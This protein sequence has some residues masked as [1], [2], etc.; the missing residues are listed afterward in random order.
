MNAKR[1]PATPQRTI[2]A[3]ARVPRIH[4]HIG[5]LMLEN[6]TRSDQLRFTRT[7]ELTL[8]EFA[9]TAHDL[10]WSRVQ[11]PARINVGSLRPGAT[12]EQAARQIARHI[13]L[14]LRDREN[15]HA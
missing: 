7:L 14:S 5:R 1:A 12:P 6:Y 3:T 9:S 10:N 8:R 15:P 13:F 11:G 2:P 4:F